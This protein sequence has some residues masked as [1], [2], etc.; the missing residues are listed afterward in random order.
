MSEKNEVATTE[1]AKAQPDG[2]WVED[3]NGKAYCLIDTHMGFPQRMAMHK[4]NLTNVDNLAYPLHLCRFVGGCEHKWGTHGLGHCIRC[5]VVVDEPRPMTFD[6]EGMELFRFAAEHNA[7]AD[8][9]R[10]TEPEGE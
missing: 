8:E 6:D 9:C 10:K 7:R 1:D 3:A 4:R 5:G 2:Q